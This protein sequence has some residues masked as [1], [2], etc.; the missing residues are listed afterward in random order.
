LRYLAR[1]LALYLGTAWAAITLNFLIPRLM[2][3]NP[4][5]ALLAR[6]RGRIDPQSEKAIRQLFGLDNASLFSQYQTYLAHLFRGHLGTSFTF[7]PAPVSTVISSALPWTLVL[8]G[9]STVISFS[10]GTLLGIVAG[11]KRGTWWW[12]ALSPISTFFSAIPYFWFAL[13]ALFV[14]S[15]KLNWF[16]ITGGYSSDLAPGFSGPFLASAV[17]HAVLPA[18]T[19]VVASVGGW[20]LGMRNMMVTTMSD[21]YVLLAEAKGLSTRRIAFTYAA[22]NA[23]LPSV[24]TF[25]MSLGFV[26]GGSVLTE[27][28]FSYPGMGYDLY[29]AVS[30]EDF[31]LMQGIF[32]V[33]TLVVLV[34]NFLADL[35]YV[36]LDPRTREA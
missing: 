15:G 32:L 22:R 13:I 18:L 20:L 6:F 12:D 5:L 10:V 23:I 14:L 7:F 21:D 11:W 4:V 17:Y 28:V 34:A 30:N 2:P 8:V 16:P 26:V 24:A 19:I 33:I 35:V 29:Q 3:G 31:P 25:T 9:L 1:R 27:I 36:F